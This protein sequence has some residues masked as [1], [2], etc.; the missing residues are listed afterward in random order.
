[1]GKKRIIITFLA[2]LAGYCVDAQTS[3]RV[4]FAD[5]LHMAYDFNQA[6]FVYSRILD[7][8]DP[9]EDTVLTDILIEKV[10]LAEN[11][12]NM[13]RYVQKPPVLTKRKFSI[14]DFFLHYPLE[15]RGWR[16]VPNVL[17]TLPER[18]FVYGL[19]APEWDEKIYYSGMGESG[20]RDIMMTEYADTAWTVPVADSVLSTTTADEIFP[21][22]SPDGKTMYFSSAGLYGVG[23]YDLYRS[24]WNEKTGTWSV[25]QNLGFPYSSPADDFLY[26][27]T[28]DGGGIL[29]A[30]NRECSRDSVV[31]YVVRKEPYPVHVP[32]TDVEELRT[33]MRLDIPV[34]EV[35]EEEEESSDIPDNEL[36]ARYEVKMAEVKALRDSITVN[37]DNL[38]EMRNEYIMSNDPGVRIRLTNRILELETALPAI[39]KSLDLANRELRDIEME[40]L[41]EG[42]FINMDIPDTPET[43]EEVISVPQYEFRKL[44]MGNALDIKLMEPEVVCDS[45]SVSETVPETEL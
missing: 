24:H 39:Q 34:E 22:L 8:L 43:V 37:M 25:P 10:L 2:V 1:M 21:L 15:D 40:F 12:K 36:T 29:F 20:T 18:N 26:M 31:V 30:S 19:Y 27:E 5:S 42:V 16:P 35:V 4:H 44:Q 23:G 7:E 38:E 33:L 32:V 3:G 28:A 17:D 9:A 11:G 13:S 6:H 14:K 45:L 41:K